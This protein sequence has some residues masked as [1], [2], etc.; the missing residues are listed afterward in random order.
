MFRMRL[1]GV[2]ENA[3]VAR[4]GVG[5]G[6][7]EV[8]GGALEPQSD[9]G[10]RAAIMQ[11]RVV[12]QSGRRKAAGEHSGTERVRVGPEAGGDSVLELRPDRFADTA[13]PLGLGQGGADTP[14]LELVVARA[15]VAAVC[16]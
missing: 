10:K 15:G 5:A 13:V 14:E 12:R 8:Q 9:K 3:P 11:I 6:L 2:G 4:L 1:T 16:G 7:V